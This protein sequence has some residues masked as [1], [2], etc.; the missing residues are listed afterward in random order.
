M[1]CLSVKLLTTVLFALSLAGCSNAVETS[2][3]VPLAGGGVAT[4]MT[5]FLEVVGCPRS[6]DLSQSQIHARGYG[7]DPSKPGERSAKQALRHLLATD[8]RESGWRADDFGRLRHE[9]DVVLF[10][11]SDDF[12]N[13][14]VAIELAPVAADKSW[15][16]TK[17]AYCNSAYPN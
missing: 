15:M 6:I 10:G 11:K 13:V 12:L 1:Q 2:P 3:R 5:D 7:P 8:Y 14:I 4:E 9:D 17:L 16:V